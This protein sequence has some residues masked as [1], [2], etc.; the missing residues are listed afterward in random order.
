VGDWRIGGTRQNMQAA[1]ANVGIAASAAGVMGIDRY[2]EKKRGK[3][4]QLK[5]VKGKEKS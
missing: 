5:D 4:V 3:K 1:L 2:D